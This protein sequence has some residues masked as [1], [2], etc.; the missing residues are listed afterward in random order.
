MDPNATRDPEEDR[1][2]GER[3]WRQVAEGLDEARLLPSREKRARDLAKRLDK[4]LERNGWR[5]FV[6]G[7]AH[8]IANGKAPQRRNAE[9]QLVEQVSRWMAQVREL[10]PGREDDLRRVVEAGLA[11]PE[12]PP[13]RKD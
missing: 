13:A 2:I 10:L 3:L 5:M 1:P 7:C 12:P 6:S 4:D 9:V 8:A 11:R